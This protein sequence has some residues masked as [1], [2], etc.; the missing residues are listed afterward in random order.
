MFALCCGYL[1]AASLYKKY[2][3]HLETAASLGDRMAALERAEVLTGRAAYETADQMQG[4]VCTQRMAAIAPDDAKRMKWL[5]VAAAEGA[6]DAFAVLARRGDTALTQLA[7]RGDIDLIRTLA[8]Q[9]LDSDSAMDA[10]QWQQLACLYG[11]DLTV[12]TMRDYHD[13]GERDGQFYDSDF[14]GGLYAAGD[15]GLELP[16]ISKAQKAEAMKRARAIYQ[17]AESR[18]WGFNR[19]GEPAAEREATCQSE[20]SEW[21]F[22]YLASSSSADLPASSAA[23]NQA[24]RGPRPL[25][26]LPWSSLNLGAPVAAA[27]AAFLGLRVLFAMPVCATD[28]LPDAFPTPKSAAVKPYTAIASLMRLSTPSASFLRSCSASF[29]SCSICF[30]TWRKV[31]AMSKP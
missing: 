17:P 8:I 26:A 30:C 25:H 2:M 19:S 21:R 3:H 24:G 23:L 15:E 10:W 5:R 11:Y 4:P 13:G 31:F 28:A 22:C 16:R 14:G 29:W 27:A 20:G 6:P 1:R 9:A 12:S 18:R 7:A